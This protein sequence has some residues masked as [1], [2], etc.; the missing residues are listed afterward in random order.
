M[1]VIDWHC[2]ALSKLAAGL[3]ELDY[4][5]APEIDA[6]LQR[7]QKGKVSVQCYAIFI[8][9]EVHSDTK[10]QAALHQVTY[11]YQEVLGK[12]PE[13]KQI[14]SWQD[15]GAL[16][17]GEIGAMLALE[18]ADPIG[19]DL[20]RLE[21]LYQLGVRSVGLTW[22]FAN[23]AADGAKEERGAGLTA[24]GREIVYFLNEK[25]MLTDV[26]HLSEK[27]FWDVM[28]LAK[29]P[30][31]S[32]SNARVLCDHPRNLTDEQACAMFAQE[33]MIH[34]VFYPKFLTPN[35]NAEISDIIRHIEHF[36][37]LCGEKYLGFGSDFDGIDQYVKGLENAAQYQNLLN[38]LLK[39]YSE[40]QVRGF[41]GENFLAYCNRMASEKSKYNK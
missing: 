9:P 38:A 32:H 24:F 4:R 20:T 14:K 13:M 30:I 35:G 23:L 37:T 1:R 10:F 27:G 41:C 29:Y 5:T 25:Q 21:I 3:G 39:T 28:E 22:N 26:S 36:C 15:F 19:N 18:G 17:E 16:Q 8:E 40:T 34:V 33:A 7:L 31:A 2:D 12:N 11:F 6:N